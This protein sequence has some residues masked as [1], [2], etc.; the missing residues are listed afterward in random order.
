MSGLVRIIMHWTAGAHY[1]VDGAKHAYHFLIDGDGTVHEGNLKPEAN[2]DVS[3]GNYAAHT[4]SFN[5]GSIG[6]S[7]CAMGQAVESPFDAGPWPI[8]ETQLESLYLLCA[9]LCETYSIPV[10]RE[11]V[12]SHAEVEPTHGIKQSG[13]WDIAW[14]PG[15]DKPGDPIAIGDDIRAKILA[16]MDGTPDEPETPDDESILNFLG[17]VYK[18]METIG[19]LSYRLRQDMEKA[20]YKP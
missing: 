19:A 7:L 12:L 2:I 17:R 5:T 18:D 8:R 4:R 15:M 11:T 9:E 10:T 13:K 1:S 14:V 20:G 6:V 16:L 3:D